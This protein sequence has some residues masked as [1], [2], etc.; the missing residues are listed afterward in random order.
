MATRTDVI[1]RAFRILGVKAE[2]EALTADQY[3]NGGDVL[4]S[5]FAELENEYAISWTLDTT[6][7]V[8]FQP[9]GLLLAVELAGEY[10][11]PRPAS[12]PAAWRRFMATVRS[13]NR[14]DFRDLDDD[15]SISTAEADAG[16][17]AL[18]Y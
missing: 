11:R 10:G 18:Y 12:R 9:L 2:D 7:D 15:G 17:R 1:E 4:D 3:A 14:D 13:D 16:L 6:P 8:S 5:L